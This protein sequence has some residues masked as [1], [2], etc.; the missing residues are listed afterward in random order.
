MSELLGLPPSGPGAT[1]SVGT[2]ALTATTTA[3]TE[4]LLAGMW[5]ELLPGRLLGPGLI[6][7]RLRPLEGATAWT[8]NVR[9]QLT[10]ALPETW[11]QTSADARSA[12]GASPTPLR[13]EV[14]ATSPMLVLR[15][16]PSAE[17][18]PLPPNPTAT[19]GSREWLGQQF[20]LYWPE[21][22][23][24]ASTLEGLQRLADSPTKDVAATP[25]APAKTVMTLTAPMS[26]A[27]ETTGLHQ[28]QH[29]VATLIDQLATATD[30]TDPERLAIAVG[31][32]GLWLEALLAQSAID[33]TQSAALT[34]DLKAQL[35]TLAQRLRLQGTG[36]AATGTPSPDPPQ[37]EHRPASHLPRPQTTENEPVPHHAQDNQRTNTQDNQRTTGLARDVE[38]MIKQIVTKQLQSLGS[39][40]GQTQW[41]L[42]L[43]FQTPSGLVA[44]E[45]DIRREQAR[46]AR[47]QDTWSLRLR[48][49]LPKLGPLY[50]QLI[51]RDQRLNASFQAA[52]SA[53]AEQIK[54]HLDDLRT[55]LEARSIEVA[56]LHAGQRPLPRPAPPLADPLIREQA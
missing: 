46:E 35:L 56:S 11:L 32:S 36:P 6:E 33:P 29:A 47:E 40:A 44:L 34:L 53:G 1:V 37:V 8:P 28:I 21:S 14:V 55:R 48:L 23:P 24:L 20:R 2:Q 9:V 54:Q 3:L 49:D 12:T 16:L 31:R 7:A 17:H 13:A 26:S 42:E 39:P 4:R 22:R 51:L 19:P 27:K 52:K 5:V 30:L 38:G 45:A 43:P 50:I 15:L 10:T 25:L 41:L 18:L